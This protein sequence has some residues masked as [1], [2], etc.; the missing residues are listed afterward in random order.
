MDTKLSDLTLDNSNKVRISPIATD[1]LNKFYFYYIPEYS[2][3][4][5]NHIPGSS[6][7]YLPDK[8]IRTRYNNLDYK[9]INHVDHKKSVIRKIVDLSNFL[10]TSMDQTGIH[11]PLNLHTS[12]N[13]HPGKKRLICARYLGLETVPILEQSTRPKE[14]LTRI[15]SLEEIFEIYGTDISININGQ[16]FE[17]SWHGDTHMRDPNGYDDWYTASATR[18]TGEVLYREYL[19][20]TGLEVLN[21]QKNATVTQK[22]FQTHYRTTRKNKITVEI[23]DDSI[24]SQVLD[25]WEL[26]YHI[27][28]AVYM[29]TCE[30]GKLRIINDFASTNT[31]LDNCKIYR[32]LTRKKLCFN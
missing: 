4:R 6:V 25:F 14:G 15:N 1:I 7:D 5:L 11:A 2:L 29:K 13:I 18:S 3:E 12:S 9:L 8:K 32:S 27:D 24:L 17:V 26:Y 20:S 30:T 23:L 28:P 19:L 31:I 21:S 16:K 10:I 22:K